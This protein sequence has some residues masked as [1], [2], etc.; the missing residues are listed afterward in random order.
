VPAQE[1]VCVGS[2]KK[3]RMPPARLFTAQSHSHIRL[4]WSCRCFTFERFGHECQKLAIGYFRH[5]ELVSE[6]RGP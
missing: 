5:P 1:D 2:A 6:A 3:N 4:I